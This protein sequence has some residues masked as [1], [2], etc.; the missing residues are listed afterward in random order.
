MVAPQPRHPHLDATFHPPAATV[1]PGVVGRDHAAM[2]LAAAAVRP[3]PAGAPAPLRLACR[4]KGRTATTLDRKAC[5]RCGKTV[6]WRGGRGPRV[7]RGRPIR[8]LRQPLPHKR[9]DP[10]P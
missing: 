10:T 3:N 7:D 9:P 4:P 6:A 2:A 8:P 1:G 5:P